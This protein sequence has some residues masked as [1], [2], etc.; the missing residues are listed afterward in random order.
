MPTIAGYIKKR[1]SIS[2]ISYLGSLI[3]LEKYMFFDFHKGPPF[4]FID[5]SG[6]K[7]ICFHY[8]ESFIIQARKSIIIFFTNFPQEMN[9]KSLTSIVYLAKNIKFL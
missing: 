3:E 1:S 6:K 9:I 8:L 2:P 4:V 7:C 5:K